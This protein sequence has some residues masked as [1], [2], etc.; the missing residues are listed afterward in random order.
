MSG[1]FQN[2]ESEKS[3]TGMGDTEAVKQSGVKGFGK[4]GGAVKRGL[5]HA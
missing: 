4:I 5:S 2:D 1:A 3:P